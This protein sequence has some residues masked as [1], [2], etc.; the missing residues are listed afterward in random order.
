MRILLIKMSSMGDVF[1]TFPAL[2]DAQAAIS[3]LKVDWIVEK[4]FAEIPAWHPVVV[5]VYPIE[6][7]KWRKHPWRYR[8]DIKAFFA[9]IQQH[10]Y[11]L[12]IDAQGLLKSAWVMRKLKGKK[13]GLDW[14]SAREPLASWFYDVKV[15]VDKNQHAIWRLRELFAT[16]LGY[17]LPN[18]QHIE[19]GL[20]TQSWQPLENLQQPYVVFLHGTTWDTKLWPEERWGELG[21]KLAEQG[22]NLVMPWGNIEEQQRALRMTENIQKALKNNLHPEGHKAWSNL[23]SINTHK[24]IWVPEQQLSLNEMARCLKFAQ[25]VVSV[26]TGL[27]HVAAAL[28]VP[29]VV[30]YRVTD[31]LKVGA[32][33]KKVQ[34]LN[35]PLASQ[36]IKQ[37]HSSEQEKTS[38]AGLSVQQVISTWQNP[39]SLRS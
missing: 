19:Y 9:Q 11:D 13:V 29:M 1:H 5:K 21:Q 25:S 23:D 30:L 4:S 6:L 24:F 37:F 12:I 18:S 22:L 14:S 20:N 15:A 28:D 32:M 27:S 7:R 36:Y 26:D 39:Q 2:S 10:N 38:L 8:A 3:N 35:S 16:A 17:P 34:Y 33:G 31:P